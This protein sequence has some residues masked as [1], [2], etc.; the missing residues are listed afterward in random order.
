MLTRREAALAERE[1]EI[2]RFRKLVEEKPSGKYAD[3]FREKTQLDYRNASLP[4]QV[5]GEMEVKEEFSRQLAFQQE[6]FDELESK[7][8]IVSKGFYDF[9]DKFKESDMLETHLGACIWLP[10]VMLRQGLEAGIIHGRKGTDN[11]S[12]SASDLNAEKVY[13]DA[14]TALNDVPFP[15]LEQLGACAKEKI[16][17][18]QDLMVMGVDEPKEDEVEALVNPESESTPVEEVKT[19]E[20]GVNVLTGTVHDPAT[21]ASQVNPVSTVHR[22]KALYSSTS[23]M[24]SKHQ[25]ISY[26][27]IKWMNDVKRVGI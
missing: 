22:N 19:V 1:A 11:N 16:S 25:M 6:R 17:Y 24:V 5:D 15:L 2:V 21:N 14:I 8:W 27:T 4:G 18:I 9:L 23:K 10:S 20:S 12:I 3:L 26:S 7:K 13:T